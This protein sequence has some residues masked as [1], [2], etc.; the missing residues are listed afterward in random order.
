MRGQGGYWPRK[1]GT[2]GEK[3][4]DMTEVRAKDMRGVSG[5]EASTTDTKIL[6]EETVP[7]HIKE[8]DKQERIESLGFRISICTTQKG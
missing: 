3:E 7:V 8:Q 5:Q 4:G 1:E 2:K 6:F